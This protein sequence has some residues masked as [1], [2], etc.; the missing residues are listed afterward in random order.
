MEAR[1]T[2]FSAIL[3]KHMTLQKIKSCIKITI[4]DQQ[5]PLSFYKGINQRAWPML[6]SINLF[7]SYISD[8]GSLYLTIAKLPNLNSVILSRL[9]IYL[10]RCNLTELGWFYIGQAD[11]PN[12]T[13]IKL[14]GI[15]WNRQNGEEV[16]NRFCK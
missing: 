12:I 7:N 11:W 6:R 9:R 1:N 2:I 16:R 5:A 10:G 14:I 15:K 4:L 8:E 3:E 13:E